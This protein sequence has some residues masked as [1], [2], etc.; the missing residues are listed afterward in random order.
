M[1]DFKSRSDFQSYLV[2]KRRLHE[3]CSRPDEKSPLLLSQSV[4]L[5]SSDTDSDV[6]ER[7]CGLQDLSAETGRKH[8][9]YE[10]STSAPHRRSLSASLARKWGRLAIGRVARSVL[11]TVVAIITGVSKPECQMYPVLSSALTITP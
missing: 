10:H 7:G 5:D 6:G 11:I 2:D 8:F 3:M 1:V 4:E 9:H